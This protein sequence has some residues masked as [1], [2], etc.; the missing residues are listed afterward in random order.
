MTP[1]STQFTKNNHAIRRHFVE[2]PSHYTKRDP[3]SI[4]QL[5][6]FHV[7]QGG[8][9]VLRPDEDGDCL[10]AGPPVVLIHGVTVR[11][12]I[13]EDAALKD[14]IRQLKKLADWLERNPD[15]MD[16]AMPIKAR[17][18]YDAD[19][20]IPCQFETSAKHFD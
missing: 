15:L 6:G 16:L 14:A 5:E 8:D 10:H 9:D 3:K 17:F 12:R 4:L 2:N 1:N 18:D 7:T 20:G 19:S 11:V 13:P